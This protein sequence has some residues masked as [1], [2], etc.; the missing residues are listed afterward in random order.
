MTPK[1]FCRIWNSGNAKDRGKLFV[2]FDL[3]EAEVNMTIPVTNP[4]APIVAVIISG[5]A[6]VESA[7]WYAIRRSDDKRIPMHAF[8]MYTDGE[9]TYQEWAALFPNKAFPAEFKKTFI[10]VFDGAVAPDYMKS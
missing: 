10:E 1:E 3:K 7:I 8:R 5:Y 2:D 6:K 9:R 4:K